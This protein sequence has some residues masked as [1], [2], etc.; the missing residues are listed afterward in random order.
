MT[1]RLKELVLKGPS[2]DQLKA[3]AIKEGMK[4]LRMCALTKVAMGQTTIEEAIGN[5]ASDDL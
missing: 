5:S 1:P 3:L 4:T 2:S